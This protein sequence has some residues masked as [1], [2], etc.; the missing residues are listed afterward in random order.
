MNGFSP[1]IAD[2]CPADG[3]RNNGFTG[4]DNQKHS[5]PELLISLGIYGMGVCILTILIKIAVTLKEEIAPT[6]Q[7]D[8]N[9]L[10]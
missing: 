5:F 10:R 2:R 9:S 8:L 3:H 7:I 1:D 6:L 4:L